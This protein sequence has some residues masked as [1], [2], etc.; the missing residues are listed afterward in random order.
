MGTVN[1]GTN[2]PTPVSKASQLCPGTASL[3]RVHAGPI[4]ILGVACIYASD[5]IQINLGHHH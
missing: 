2:T 5:L 3:G 1:I 4:C